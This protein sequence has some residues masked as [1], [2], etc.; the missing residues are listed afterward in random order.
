MEQDDPRKAKLQVVDGMRHG[1]LCKG[2]LTLADVLSSERAAY[3]SP[4]RDP[5]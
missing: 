1:L 5:V 4:S 3:Q 2:A